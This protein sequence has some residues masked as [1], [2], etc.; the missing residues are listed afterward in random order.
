M[1]GEKI[2]AIQPLEFVQ[3][4]S[5]LRL[6]AI[7]DAAP[8]RAG[9][10]WLFDGPGLY[11]PSPDVEIVE[12]V[13]GVVLGPNDALHLR[14]RRDCVDRAGVARKTGEKWLVTTLGAY[15]VGVDEEI[16]QRVG[17]QI[18]TPHVAMHLRAT[19]TFTDAYGKQRRVGDEWLVTREQSATHLLDVYETLVQ[20]VPLTVLSP[21]Q[22]AVVSNPYGADDKPQAGRQINVVGPATLFARPGEKV[23]GPL[24]VRVLGPS[25]ALWVTALE[26]FE[27]EGGVKR[28]AGNRWLVFG[29][30]A[31]VPPTQVTVVSHVNAVIAIPALNLY[32]F[33]TARFYSVVLLLLAWFI[34]WLF[35]SGSREAA[36][37]AA[38]VAA[39]AV[40]AAAPAAASATD[41]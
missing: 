38:V 9:S 28:K 13:T 1:P 32:V 34:W 11:S 6:R 35:F 8:H 27:D 14:A 7:R 20:L 10:E 33:P 5:A 41:L 29:P 26:S 2:G 12:R 25:S 4:H 31:Y 18:L 21:T 15:I 24:D 37:A 30:R 19:Q 23:N 22:Y 3:K 36:A 16:V 39:P 17:A 40:E